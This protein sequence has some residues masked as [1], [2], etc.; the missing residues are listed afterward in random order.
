MRELEIPDV[1]VCA[2]PMDHASKI[3]GTSTQEAIARTL[4]S[5]EKAPP[6]FD[7]IHCIDCD[8]EIPAARL[9]TGAF[10]DIHCQEKYELKRK[11]YRRPE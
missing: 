1:E 6:E 11:G 5:I 9:K 3:E 4:A 10:R 8:H 2:D 7:G